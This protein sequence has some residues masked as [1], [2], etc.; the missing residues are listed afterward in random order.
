MVQYI[1]CNQSAALSIDD[2]E[3]EVMKLGRLVAPL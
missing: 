3:E 1:I 2:A